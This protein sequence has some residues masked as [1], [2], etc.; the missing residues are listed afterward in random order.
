MSLPVISELIRLKN[1]NPGTS[2]DYTESD[3]ITL[4]RYNGEPLNHTQ[5]DDNLELLRRALLGLDSNVR[6]IDTELGNVTNLITSD[7]I[8]ELWDNRNFTQRFDQYINQ[9]L[10]D[11]INNILVHETYDN[12]ISQ[13]IGDYVNNNFA[14][15]FETYLTDNGDAFWSSVN[16]DITGKLI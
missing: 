11:I 5:A 15:L 13:Y 1:N 10:G 12:H 2:P 4:R 9:Q 16:S 3:V 8:E 6:H 14:N 7:F